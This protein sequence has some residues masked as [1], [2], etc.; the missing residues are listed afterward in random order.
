[1]KN[2]YDTLEFNQ[3]KDRIKNYCVGNIAK[4]QITNLQPYQ[5]LEE[6]KLRQKYLQQAMQLIYQYGRLPL[7]YYDDIEPLLLKANKDGTL[8]PEDFVQIVYLLNNVKEIIN[9]LAEK[10]LVENELLQLCNQLVLPKQ[11]LKDINRCIDGSG[12]VLDSASSQLRQIRRRILSIEASIRSKIEQI[13]VSNK[14][15]LSQ[16]AISSRNNHLVLPVKAGNKNHVK[17]IVHAISAT[18]ATMFIEPEAIVAMNNQLINARDEETKEINRILLELSKMVKAN[19]DCLHED[20]ELLI[21]IDVIFA[22]ASYG[23][24]IDGIVPE[25]SDN[26][27]VFSLKK[28]RHPLIDRDK[29][30]ANDIVL[31]QP[32]RM[33]LISGSNTGGK[34]VVL[35]T[36]G[37]LSL[38]GLC[39]MA[40]PCNQ[41]TIP[42]FDQICVDLGDEQSIEQSLSTFS[43][44]MKRLVEITNEVSEKSLVL[45]DEIGSGTDPKEGQSIAEAILR[46]L[47]QINPLIV[48]ST[49]Y[50]GL[51]EFAKNEDYIL[52]AA[53]EFDQEKMRPTYR[54]IEGSVGN[55]YA[56]EI[57]SRLGLK[58]EIVDLAYQIKESSLT[59]SDKLIEKLQ[60]E[61]TQV[62]LQKDRLETLNQEATKKIDKYNRLINNFEKQKDDLMEQAKKQANQLLEDSKQEID[63]VVEDLKKQATLKQHVVIDAKRNLDLLKHEEKKLV[64][65]SKHVYQIGDIVKVL[66]ANRQGE[67]LSINKKGILTIDMSGLKLNAKPE[68][69]SFISKKVKP[70]KVKSNLKSLRKSTNQSYELNIIGK[71]YEE[72]MLLVDKFLDDALV[73]NYSMVRIIHGM[74]TGVLRNGVRKMLD[75]HKYVVSYRDGGPNEGGLG[76]T[77]VYFE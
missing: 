16:E 55:S 74:G 57:S 24:K 49:H 72:A 62:Q 41:A 4:E 32:K 2:I 69:V 26:Y 9:Y 36:A 54:L 60:D 11:L 13:K 15:Y 68:E 19:Y 77:L 51:K 28:A 17:G 23:V 76:A 29:V 53:V 33:L 20:Q 48:A 46:Y 38:M 47:H 65:K 34:T 37:L 71:R 59:D 21:D 64:D 40:V 63:L 10:E 58:K 73:N 66:S 27:E 70:K 35:K 75:K 39:A 8:F 12:N 22:N 14:D 45:L 1:M 5:D 31:T 56:I 7:G 30:V 44:H 42:M 43:S 52:V 50:S 67:V 61:L 25:I 3:I 6:L 18:G